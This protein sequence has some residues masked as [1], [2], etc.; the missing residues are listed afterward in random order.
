[1]LTGNDSDMYKCIVDFKVD[2]L[3]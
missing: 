1:M 2:S 3:Q